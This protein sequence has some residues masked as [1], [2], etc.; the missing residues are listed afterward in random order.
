M[1]LAIGSLFVPLFG[2]ANSTQQVAGR[3]GDAL[4]PRSELLLQNESLRRQNQELRFQANQA[5]GMALE[6]ARLRQLLGWQQQKRWKLKLANVVL[7]EPSNWWRSVQIDL[8][9]RNG[10]KANMAVL[11]VEGL[12]GRVSSVGLTRS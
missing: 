4:L 9:S 1:K 3:A 12:I 5:D 11:T 10:I 8:G 6:N 2:L 7:R